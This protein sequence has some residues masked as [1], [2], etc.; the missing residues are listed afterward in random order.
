MLK[1][2]KVRLYPT[3]Q[4]KESLAKAFG[5]TR[6][7]WN[8]FLALTNET[9]KQTGKGLS[10]YDLQKQ[11][12]SLKKEYEWLTQTYSQC[13][14][15]VCL[16][17][18]RSFINFFEKRSSFPR[19]KSK[20]GKQS[21]SYPQNVKIKGDMIIF[22]KLGEI[23]AKIHRPID[24]QIKTVTIS[25]NKAQQ[26]YAS[27]LFEDGKEQPKP[28]T[29]G[30]TI[31]LDMGIKD[32]CVT[33]DGS[34]FSNP[35]WLEKYERNLR[36]KHKSLSRKQKGSNNRNKARIKVAKVHNKISRT[37]EDFHHK[38]SRRIVNE[39]QVVICENL[40]IKGMVRNHCLAK[41]IQQVGWGQFQTMLK[42]KC[43][44]EGKV[45]LE[46]DRFF[47]SSKTCNHCLNVVDSLPLDIRRWECPRCKTKHD[48]D[49]NASC[50]IRDEGLRI[51]SL[52][53]SES[54]YC[55]DVRRDSRGRKKSTVTPS[56]G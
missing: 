39:N 46:I 18:S 8:K 17:L 29:E 42:Y 43:E 34:K 32:F 30:K 38:L 52:G 48:R 22:P 4:Q 49:V 14:Q 51:M 3:Y 44:Q 20:H 16:N 15:V 36:N 12:P 28:N 47:P 45:Y 23:Y 31:G 41:S 5:S 2:V 56:V 53:T 19:F 37:R 35:R 27:I 25:K 1:I 33:S 26:Y 21:L 13:L 55:P 10:R 6:W 24:G 9:Y 54:A 11:L 50:N 7:L 40:N